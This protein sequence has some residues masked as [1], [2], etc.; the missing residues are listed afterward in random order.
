MHLPPNEPGGGPFTMLE[1][2][3][4]A[5]VSLLW[6]MD[7][8]VTMLFEVAFLD[9]SKEWPVCKHLLHHLVILPSGFNLIMIVGFASKFWMLFMMLCGFVL[10]TPSYVS[11][12]MCTNLCFMV[13]SLS[14]CKYVRRNVPISVIWYLFYVALLSRMTIVQASVCTYF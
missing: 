1:E 6:K 5:V 13:L 8:S 4:V 7:L 3:N 14:Y 9:A 10:E 2:A 12:Q 11:T